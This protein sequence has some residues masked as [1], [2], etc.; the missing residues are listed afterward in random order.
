MKL[1]I[2]TGNDL[3]TSKV[4]LSV[5][6][7]TNQKDTYYYKGQKYSIRNIYILFN[8]QN[9]IDISVKVTKFV[10]ITHLHETMCCDTY[11]VIIFY[12]K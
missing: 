11:N 1:R 6:F 12:G 3:E 8:F 2:L 9:S 5:L 4:P 7:C 10:I